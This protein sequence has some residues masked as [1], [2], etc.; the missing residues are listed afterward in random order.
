MRWPARRRT[1]RERSQLSRPLPRWRHGRKPSSPAA[2]KLTDPGWQWLWRSPRLQRWTATGSSLRSM[3]E[4]AAVARRQCGAA[5]APYRG[6]PELMAWRMTRPVCSVPLVQLAGLRTVAHRRVSWTAGSVLW[7]RCPC[8]AARQT[9]RAH[10]R[11]PDP[12]RCLQAEC[13]QNSPPMPPLRRPHGSSDPSLP[14]PAR[15]RVSGG[16]FDPRPQKAPTRSVCRSCL[17]SPA[18]SGDLG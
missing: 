14:S 17:K 18:E 13:S 4:V 12:G 8:F 2:L 1:D 10:A 11:M 16:I 15:G 7:R 9:P 6:H 5:A 3:E